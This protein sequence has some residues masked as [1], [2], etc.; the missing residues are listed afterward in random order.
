MRLNQPES[1]G[2][3]F[4]L[5][6]YGTDIGKR[7]KIAR[8][9][10][11]TPLSASSYPGSGFS[12]YGGADSATYW[13]V[14][15]RC[16]TKLRIP[17]LVISWISISYPTK[18]RRSPKDFIVKQSVRGVPSNCRSGN[19]WRCQ[20]HWSSVAPPPIVRLILLDL[21]LSNTAIPGWWRW[22]VTSHDITVHYSCYCCY[23]L[24]VVC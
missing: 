21:L 23:G 19:R 18:D 12:N 24:P 8:V 7:K 22:R 20:S 10:N 4:R 3:H 5:Q 16:S 9:I 14:P 17:G 11:R 1:I 15:S 6:S 2:V 13:H